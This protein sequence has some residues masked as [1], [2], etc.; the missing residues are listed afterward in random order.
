MK[1]NTNFNTF[2]KKHKLK[3]NQVIFHEAVCKNNKIIEPTTSTLELNTFWVNYQKKH[4]FNPIHNHSGLFSFVIWLK[5]PY[6]HED[7][8]KLPFLDGM[9]DEGKAAGE[10]Q[11]QIFDILGKQ[12]SL[13]YKL[14]KEF[15][16]KMLLFPSQLRHLVNPFY[17]TDEDRVSISGNISLA[18]SLDVE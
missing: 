18:V 10:F 5:I 15:E 3:I 9:V 8:C 12:F 6:D 7:Q 1:I 11:F 4:E 13:P 2:K 14:G 17:E 16:G